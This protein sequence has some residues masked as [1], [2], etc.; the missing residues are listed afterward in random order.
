M[1]LT[2]K[3]SIIIFGCAVLLSTFS[4]RDA[5]AA[6][7]ELVLYF[8]FDEGAGKT[9]KDASGNKHEGEFEATP[10]WVDGKFGKALEYDGTNHVQIPLTDAL[11]ELTK[12]FT[13]AFWAKRNDKQPGTWNYMVAADRVRWAVIYNSD[14]K[15]Y[16]WASNPD[17]A[18]QAVTKDSL[19]KDWT[20]IAVTFDTGD[21]VKIRFNGE[22]AA[23]SAG[24]PN[25]TIP[26]VQCYQ[27]G[28]IATA[29]G[30][31]AGEQKF[32][33]AIDDLVIYNG[34]LTEAEIQRDMKGDDVGGLA[35][36]AS[37]KLAV[38]WGRLKAR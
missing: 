17:W 18:M 28:S 23:E 31:P 4:A 2:L 5:D 16:V 11:K 9:V 35:V 15:V 26:I 1:K 20:H 22:I 38:T 12:D 13:V 36:E 3:L 24:K 7:S 10:K 6:N 30:C 21:K 25:E 14:Q 32:S 37:G 27:I 34:I 29:G 33:G 8:P 19:P